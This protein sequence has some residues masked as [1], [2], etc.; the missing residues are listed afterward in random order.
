MKMVRKIKRSVKKST[1][2]SMKNHKS[3]RRHT[4]KHMRKHRL[5][6]KMGGWTYATEMMD[7]LS[8]MNI[9]D[10][11]KDQIV[12]K[13]VEENDEY[14]NLSSG[15]EQVEKNPLFVT[16]TTDLIKSEL[17]QMNKSDILPEHKAKLEKLMK[18]FFPYTGNLR[19]LNMPSFSFFGK[20]PQQEQ[21]QQQKPQQQ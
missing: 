9:D 14:K 21:P 13:L 2:R 16:Q 19:N 12:N 4:K 18:L 5:R 3:S 11:T 15:A 6:K 1:K 7:K 17:K 20:N 8:K 10:M